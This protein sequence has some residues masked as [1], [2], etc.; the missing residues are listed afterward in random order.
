MQLQ[1]LILSADVIWGQTVKF[2]GDSDLSPVDW[3]WSWFSPPT[4]PLVIPEEDNVLNSIYF[5]SMANK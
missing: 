2:S 1:L 4:P 5:S 3:E